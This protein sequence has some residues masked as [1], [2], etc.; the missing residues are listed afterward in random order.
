[1]EIEELEIIDFFKLTLPL[2]SATLEELKSLLAKTEVAYR[3]KRH[4]LT[5]KPDYLYLVR[6][7]AVRIED[8]NEALFSLLGEHQWFGYSAQL[9]PYTHLCQEDT[10]YYRIDKAYFYAL[11]ADNATIENFFT[12]ANLESSIQSQN[13]IKKDSLLSNSVLSMSRSNNV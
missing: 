1:M 5:I 3:R 12:E 4:I 7:G 9:L 2:D 11:F 6:K 10:L 13:L 8:E